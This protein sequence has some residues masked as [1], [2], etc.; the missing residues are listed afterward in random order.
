MQVICLQLQQRNVWIFTKQFL[1][2]DFFPL[3]LEPKLSFSAAPTDTNHCWAILFI[4]LFFFFFKREVCSYIIQNQIY[5]SFFLNTWWKINL[6][7][8]LTDLSD[9]WSTKNERSKIP[10][11]KTVGSGMPA[12]H[13][14][15]LWSWLHRMF[16][17][18]TC[19]SLQKSLHLYI[20]ILTHSF[21]KPVMQKKY[22]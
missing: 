12:K 18:L 21:R 16:T 17:F 11:I 1:K 5:R 4:L 3:I 13:K 6:L 20:L 14:Q 22:S 19:K 9:L 7:W 8:L 10:S 15:E 2:N